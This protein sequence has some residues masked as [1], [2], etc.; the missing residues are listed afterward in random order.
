MFKHIAD[1]EP[2]DSSPGKRRKTDD[3]RVSPTKSRVNNNDYDDD[4][5]DD[6]NKIDLEDS[7]D[8]EEDLEDILEEEVVLS[9]SSTTMRNSKPSPTKKSV[10]KRGNGADLSKM[11]QGLNVTS[12]NSRHRPTSL[13][14]KPSSTNFSTQNAFMCY[15]WKDKKTN[16][17]LTIE[18]LV[19]GTGKTCSIQLE[20]EYPGGSQILTVTQALPPSWFSMSHFENYNNMDEYNVI[21]RYGARKNF[22]KAVSADKDSKNDKFLTKQVFCLPFR[23]DDVNM[24]TRYDDT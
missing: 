22:I 3:T 10:S 15:A 19:H 20:E 23:C 12:T 17:L 7:S 14:S 4:D 13:S 16:Q 5:N 9:P 21:Q 6:D 18:V 24:K 1:K 2:E 11:L 8:E